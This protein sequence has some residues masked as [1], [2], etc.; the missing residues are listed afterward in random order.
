MHKLASNRFVLVWQ[1]LRKVSQGV[2]K[3]LKASEDLPRRPK[4]SRMDGQMDGWTDGRT[5]RWMDGWMDGWSRPNHMPSRFDALQT[6]GP[7][8]FR[9]FP[10]KLHSVAKRASF[11]VAFWRDF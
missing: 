1:F 8:N 5:D 9:R 4:A 10:N 2:S 6:P 3:V 7:V 11:Y